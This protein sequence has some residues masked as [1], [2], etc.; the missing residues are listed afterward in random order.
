MFFEKNGDEYMFWMYEFT[1]P[2]DYNSIRLVRSSRYCSA[3]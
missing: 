1:V 3:C 2:E